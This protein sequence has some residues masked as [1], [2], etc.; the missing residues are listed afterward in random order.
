MFPALVEIPAEGKFAYKE[1]FGT[2]RWTGGVL[3]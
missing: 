1:V 2:T 3:L